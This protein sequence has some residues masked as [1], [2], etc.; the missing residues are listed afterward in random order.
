[1]TLDEVDTAMELLALSRP[2]TT[3]GPREGEWEPSP[4]GTA[5]VESL[6]EAV[7]IEICIA[8]LVGAA[9]I[10]MRQNRR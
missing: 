1:V 8:L 9:T 4:L 7:E 3:P 5:R 10:L 2:P 6:L